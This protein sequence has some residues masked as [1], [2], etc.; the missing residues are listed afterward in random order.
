VSGEGNG[1]SWIEQMGYHNH[2]LGNSGDKEKD[3][4]EIKEQP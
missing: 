3:P 2:L 4:I 1:K